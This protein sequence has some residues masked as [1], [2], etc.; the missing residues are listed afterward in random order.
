MN[1]GLFE[2]SPKW[3]KRYKVGDTIYHR[4]EG[5]FEITRIDGNRVQVKRLTTPDGK[6]VSN[7]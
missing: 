4:A 5:R 7:M 3:A 1:T 6:V 2:D